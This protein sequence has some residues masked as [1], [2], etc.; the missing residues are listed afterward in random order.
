MQSSFIAMRAAGVSHA[1]GHPDS[2]Q[3]VQTLEAV[4]L[5]VRQGEMLTLIGPSG[6]GKTT[7]LNMFASLIEPTV[8]SV[9]V[10]GS[11][12]TG[13]MPAKIAFIFQ[14]HALF[15]WLSIIDNVR[16][17][18]KFRGVGSAEAT[19]R[20]LV[21][22]EAV[23]LADFADHF[24]RQLSGGMKQRASL[25]RGLSLETPIMLMDEPF[26]ALDEQTR[27]VLGEDLSELLSRTGK[28]IVFV[29]HSLGEAVL[30]SDRIAIFSA[31][32]GRINSIIEID[33]PHPRR[34]AFA[35]SEKFARLRTQLYEQLHDQVRKSMNDAVH[36]RSSA[37][38]PAR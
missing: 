35:A 2:D 34:S 25:A 13:P 7:L 4:D 14:E 9:S 11:P 8:G 28:T 30:L 21:A 15:P 18:L 12:V 22:L 10:E 1:Y 26:A 33:E 37:K 16:I 3:H 27:M 32:P 23:G 29:T 31:R 20:S 6:C 38:T 24:P 36:R 5:E 19:H 17:A